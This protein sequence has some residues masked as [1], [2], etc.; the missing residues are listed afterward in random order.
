MQVG[1][2]AALVTACAAVASTPISQKAIKSVNCN[3]LPEFTCLPS[4]LALCLSFT[5]KAAAEYGVEAI[6]SVCG[7]DWGDALSSCTLDKHMASLEPD[8]LL[9]IASDCFYDPRGEQ[10]NSLQADKRVVVM[11]LGTAFVLSCANMRWIWCPSILCVADY[12]AVFATV[13][14]LLM[15]YGGQFLTAYRIRTA[16]SF[17]VK[18]HG[19]FSAC[20]CLCLFVCVCMCGDTWFDPL[21][22]FPVAL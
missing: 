20:V 15:R 4:C 2:S 3:P 9:I 21:W 14:D 12:D 19:C 1:I 22:C 11:G 18:S 6:V 13:V 7:L 5:R 8:S 16:R 10:E 17:Q